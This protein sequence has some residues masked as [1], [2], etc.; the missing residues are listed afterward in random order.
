MDNLI[1]KCYG[2]RPITDVCFVV[3][4]WKRYCQTILS[5]GETFTY[6]VSYTVTQADINAGTTL[7]NTASVTTTELP[8][9]EEDTAETPITQAPSLTISKTQTSGENPVTVPGVIGYDI[10]VT[11]DG[12]TSLTNVV[13]NLLPDNAAGTVVQRL[14]KPLPADE[15][16]HR[17]DACYSVSYTVTQRLSAVRPQ[18][19]ASVTTAGLPEPEEDTAGDTHYQ[20]FTSLTMPKRRPVV[21]I[22][23]PV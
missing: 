20:S 2:Y 10:V 8:D 17:W 5:I 18:L 15:F 11:N 21:I 19:M 23:V 9:P 13:L 14:V 6:T 12:T 7:V 4:R 16:Y 22:N 1:D 3:Q